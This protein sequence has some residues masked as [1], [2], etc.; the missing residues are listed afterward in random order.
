MVRLG[1]FCNECCFYNNDSKTCYRGY[2]DRFKQRN[3]EIQWE[4]DG[5]KI[6]RVCPSRRT[7]EWQD[8]KDLQQCSI[9]VDKTLYI[10]G[11][12]I[13]LCDSLDELNSMCTK[14]NNIKNINNFNIIVAH[15]DKIELNNVAKVCSDK[16]TNT[17]F[18]CVKN[19]KDN[20]QY[21]LFESFRKSA[22]NGYVFI[23]NAN[24][25]FDENMFDK[26]NSIV[27]HE[28][29][30]LLHVEG[31][32]NGIHQQVTMSSVYKLLKGD[33]VYSLSD[34]IKE[35]AAAQ[36]SDPQIMT[37]EQIDEIYNS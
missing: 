35:M 4:D 10:K 37:W 5:P 6:D 11:S 36:N 26:I 15:D 30:R 8:G 24:K 14:L 28:L 20:T 34:K 2:L 29:Y 25:D 17:K 22:K 9:E 33:L 18:S 12:I 16:I 7:L 13:L 23:L 31:L 19:Y 1:T 27:N 32:N 3:A 21:I